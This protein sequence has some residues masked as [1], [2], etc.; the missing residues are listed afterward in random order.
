MTDLSEYASHIG[1]ASPDVAAAASTL[2]YMTM[3]GMADYLFGAGDPA[4]ARDL[5]GR[6]FR[7]E[8]NRFSYR[9]AD[10]ATLSGQ[11]TG[12]LISYSGRVMRS[13][14]LQMA[15]ELLRQSG[16]VDFARFMGR[17]LPVAGVREAEDDEYFISNVAVL[18]ER[19]GRGIGTKLLSRAEDK[20]REQGFRKLS[21]TVDTKNERAR[22][23]YARIGFAV[24]HTVHVEA[25]RKRFG[26][27]GLHRM[28]KVLK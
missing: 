14:D 23:L 28:I 15:V 19:Q 17:V 12:L 24:T 3:G 2:I 4:R 27:A 13:L 16:F 22:A 1:P 6:L 9:F 26:Y 10:V 11:T 20:A 7:L 21:L 8:S 18:P 5:L 25:L